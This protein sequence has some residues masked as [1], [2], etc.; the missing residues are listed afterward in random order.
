MQ[1]NKTAHCEL[2]LLYVFELCFSSVSADGK[3][4]NIFNLI[5]VIF[6]I[7]KSRRPFPTNRCS[8]F[9]GDPDG[10]RGEIFGL[11][12]S[13]EIVCFAHGEIKSVLHPPA[14]GF[15]RE[16]ISPPDRAISPVRRTDFIEKSTA[17]AVLFSWLG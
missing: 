4:L 12:S 10:S 13:D 14:G 15:H 2:C 8:R 9:A 5:N 11:A 3:T 1:I 7:M 17:T 16:A 6:P